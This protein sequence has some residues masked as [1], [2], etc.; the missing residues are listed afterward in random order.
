MYELLEQAGFRIPEEGVRTVAQ[1]RSLTRD[2]ALGYL[3]TGAIH[4]LTRHVADESVRRA[5]VTDAAGR[6]EELRRHDGSFDAT[7]VRLDLLAQRPG[8]A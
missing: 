4:A 2:G 3:T 5:L 1:R 8:Q 7:F 6:I